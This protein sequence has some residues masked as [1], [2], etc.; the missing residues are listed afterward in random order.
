MFK[1]RTPRSLLQNLR[2]VFWPSM[3][4]MRACVYVKHRIMR[5][6]DTNYSIAAGLASGACIS[7]TPFMGTHFLHALAIAYIC[8]GNY[9]AAVVG[10][11]WGNPWT[12]PFLFAASH[13]VG[14]Y[15]LNM[16]GVT[17]VGIMPNSLEWDA[18]V[19][20]LLPIS[21]GGYICSII[22]WPFYLLIAYIIVRNTKAARVKY[23]NMK[24]HRVAK[25]ITGQS[26]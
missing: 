14:T 21:V 15:A 19:S 8:R 26:K 18:L 11:F 7:F 3:G 2:E 6:S 10:T 16:M 1:R 13:H 9:L 25:E 20:A 22:A 23:K 5:L 12:F 24:A 17:D 4:W